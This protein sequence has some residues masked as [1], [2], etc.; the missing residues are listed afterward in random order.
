MEDNRRSSFKRRSNPLSEKGGNKRGKFG[1]QFSENSQVSETVYRILCQSRKI[2]SVI[3]KGGGIVKALHEK[4]QAKITVADTVPGSDQRV[5]IIYSPSTK[6]PVKHNADGGSEDMGHEKNDM[7]LQCAA[8]DA[9]LKVHDRIVE[10]DIVGGTDNGDDNENVVTARLLVPNNTVGC[11][12]GK[13]GDVIQRLRSET[14]ANIRILPADQLPLYAMNTDELV[15]ISGKPGIAK[16]ALYEVSILLH[17]NPRKDKPPSGFPVPVGR[18]GLHPPG[19]SMTNLPPPAMWSER[20]SSARGAAPMRWRGEYGSENSRFGLADFDGDHAVAGG[21]EAPAEFSMKILCPTAKIGGVIGKGGSN[22]R[23]L[24]QETGTNIHV[25]D[26]SADSDE[27]VIRV[28]AIEALWNPRS[29]TI[30]AILFL[31][32]KTSDHSEKGIITSRLLIPSS[33]VGCI[34]GQGGQ[35]I[36][37]MRR[38]TK[39][40]IRVYS[41]EEKPKCAGEDEELVQV[42]GSF[43]SAKDALGEIASRYRARC[44]RDA[45]PGA[46]PAPAFSS[47]GNLTGERPSPS[48]VTRGG[49]SGGYEPFKGG[50]REYEPPSYPAPPRD[51]EPYNHS[52]PARDYEPYNHPAP[53]RDYEPHGHPPPQRD[54][55]SRGYR[56]PPRDYEPNSYPAPPMEYEPRGYPSPRRD[57][58]PQGYPVPPSAIGFPGAMD[59]KMPNSGRGSA[60][61]PGV[62][63]ASEI[64]GTRSKLQD[65]YASGSI[66]E[67]THDTYQGYGGP[68]GQMHPQQSSYH[69]NYASRPEPY[70]D[71]NPS[72]TPYDNTNPQH[73]PYPHY[74]NNPPQQGQYSENPYQY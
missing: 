54:F 66:A 11:L 35:V 7:E 61:G 24:Q 62:G 63:N 59:P 3:G 41:K 40:D 29:R 28:S 2:S 21:G 51:Y 17:Q 22:V 68:G 67:T 47:R 46:D 12:L 73:P 38:R 64:T 65:L 50:G 4:T 39:E 70:A 48:G 10:E 49:R 16:R 71:I 9:L 23:Q 53:P 19:P 14:G 32:D 31:Q 20:G 1:D 13:K 26:V 30:D 56:A 52:A 43:G 25:D 44:L 5:I 72:N 18:Q 15:Q 36:N 33:K 60:M 55:E 57:F 8:Q 42:S 45:K 34:L 74:Q 58:E 37:E 27:R 69:D 6:K